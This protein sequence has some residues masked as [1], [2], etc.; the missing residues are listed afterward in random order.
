MSIKFAP[1]GGM[2]ANCINAE[3]KCDH[4]PFHK[5]KVISKCKVSAIKIVACNEYK[6]VKR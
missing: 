1:K 4:L 3:R 5:M 6:K 2:C